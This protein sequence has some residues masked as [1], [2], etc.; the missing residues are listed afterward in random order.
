[1]PQKLLFVCLGNIC[2]SPAAEG[3]VRDLCPEVVT[4][5]SGTGAWHVGEPPYGPMQAAARA[6]G[7][8]LS[9]MRARPFTRDDFDRFD[10]IL[11]LDHG[12]P[13]NDGALRP[14]GDTAEGTL[15][16]QQD[17]QAGVT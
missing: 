7:T 6:P 4:D 5:S 11:G 9:N 12:N 1:M 16:A 13:A 17:R 15:L 2:R 10:L 8:D 3:L 14:A